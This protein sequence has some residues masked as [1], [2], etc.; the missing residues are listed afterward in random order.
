MHAVSSRLHSSVVLVGTVCAPPIV[1]GTI[2]AVCAPPILRDGFVAE[3][4]GR[5][6]LRTSWWSKIT[7][8]DCCLFLLMTK[9]REHPQFA[10]FNEKRKKSRCRG[11]SYD[12]LREA[13]LDETG[14]ARLFAIGRRSDGPQLVLM[15]SF[16][17]SITASRTLHCTSHPYTARS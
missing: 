8:L 6:G 1:R 12:F 15:D 14:E 7:I 16:S 17:A 13:S 10:Q 11:K 4:F 2:C 3:V 5:H 9:K